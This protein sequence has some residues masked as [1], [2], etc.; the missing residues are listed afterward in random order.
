MVVLQILQYT[1]ICFLLPRLLDFFLFNPDRCTAIEFEQTCCGL[2]CLHCSS[3]TIVRL[4]GGGGGDSGGGC[5]LR[6]PAAGSIS[7]YW[8][9]I[10]GFLVTGAHC[11]SEIDLAATVFDCAAEL[12]IA[13]TILVG[14]G[15]CSWSH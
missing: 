8:C 4:C 3:R 13:V 1:V 5:S 2:V 6:A 14:G 9:K 7:D 12:D 11:A 10:V 15:G